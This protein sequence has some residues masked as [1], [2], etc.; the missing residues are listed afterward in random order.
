MLFMLVTPLTWVELIFD[1]SSTLICGEPA[2]DANVKWPCPDTGVLEIGETHLTHG[3]GL[4]GV[5]K[6]RA[7][8]AQVGRPVLT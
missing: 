7:I 6:R 1:R 3:Q 8:S 2:S 4:L 5:A